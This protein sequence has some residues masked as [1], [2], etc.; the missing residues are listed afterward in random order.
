MQELFKL[1]LGNMTLDEYEKKFLELLRYIGYIKVEKVK[2]HRF[3]SELPA[4]YKDKIKF[5][6]PKTL[7]ETIRRVGYLYD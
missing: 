7:E 5:D 6:E 3:L 2:I 1:K 4:F